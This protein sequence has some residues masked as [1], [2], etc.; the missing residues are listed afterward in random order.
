MS[1]YQTVFPDRL[2]AN[3]YEG[4]I[5]NL[6]PI[7]EEQSVAKSVFSFSLFQLNSLDINYDSDLIVMTD[8]ALNAAIEIKDE[9]VMTVFMDLEVVLES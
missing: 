2:N 7:L 5:A 3:D 6:C 1:V 9:A 8:A 4:I